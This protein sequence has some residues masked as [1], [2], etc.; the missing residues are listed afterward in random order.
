MAQPTNG[1][2]I[3]DEVKAIRDGDMRDRMHTNI[4]NNVTGAT[5]GLVAGAMYGAY[6]KHNIFLTGFIGLVLG[7]F[8]SYLVIGNE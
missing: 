5:I 3:L 2:E 7:G 8:A 6:R 1:G 4:K